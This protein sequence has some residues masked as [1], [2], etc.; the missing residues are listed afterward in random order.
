MDEK[1]SKELV[2]QIKILNGKIED[3]IDTIRC[4]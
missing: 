3:L 4:K 2:N 1:T